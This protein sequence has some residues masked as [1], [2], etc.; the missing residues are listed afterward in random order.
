M[1]YDSENIFDQTVALTATRVSTNV[2][3]TSGS[4]KGNIGIGNKLYVVVKTGALDFTSGGSSTLVITV[5][6]DDNE[7]FSSATTIATSAS[8][9][10][11]AITKNK[12]LWEIALPTNCE[13]FLR[14]RYTVGTAD[15]TAGTVFAALATS[16]DGSNLVQY[17]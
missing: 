12:L 15:F 3:K 8:I 7:A 13:Q 5:E 1:S 16:P 9:A 14:L 2:I 4:S 11:A 6:T 17:V 10:K